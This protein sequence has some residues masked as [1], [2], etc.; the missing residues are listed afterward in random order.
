MIGIWIVWALDRSQLYFK[1]NATMNWQYDIK[2]NNYPKARRKSRNPKETIQMFVMLKKKK[3]DNWV[4]G[5]SRNIATDNA[6]KTYTDA[7]MIDKNAKETQ[8]PAAAL[9]SVLTAKCRCIRKWPILS[10]VLSFVRAS[11]SKHERGGGIDV[12]LAE[13]WCT[14]LIN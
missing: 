2:L 12:D 4:V 1:E 6:K 13:I 10:N 8:R 14:L 11:R 5:L 7:L 3:K 9:A